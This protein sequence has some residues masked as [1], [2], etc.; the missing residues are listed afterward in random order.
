MTVSKRQKYER[1]SIEQQEKEESIARFVSCSLQ[2]FSVVD[3]KSFREMVE[4]LDPRFCHVSRQDI[5]RRIMAMYE[6]KRAEIKSKISD[7]FEINAF[8]SY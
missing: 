1:S 3:E 4:K 2:P 6:V 7:N 5:K 8:V